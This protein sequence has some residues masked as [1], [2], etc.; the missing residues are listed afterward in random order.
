MLQDVMP[1]TSQYSVQSL[2]SA[3]FSPKT[4]EAFTYGTHCYYR[5]LRGTEEVI[6]RLPNIAISECILSTNGRHPRP[7]S[8]CCKSKIG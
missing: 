3:V 4:G 5:P 2:N 6:Y 7:G 1:F 8:L